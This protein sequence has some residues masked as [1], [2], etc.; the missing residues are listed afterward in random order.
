MDPLVYYVCIN[1][2]MYIRTDENTDDD[3]DFWALLEASQ[4][5]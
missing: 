2:Y 4:N 1:A 5:N 3:A